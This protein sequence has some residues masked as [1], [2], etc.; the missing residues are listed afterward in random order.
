M[1]VPSQ[2]VDWFKISK[3]SVDALREDSAALRAENIALRT[4]LQTTKANFSW[5]TLRVNAL[6]MERA[7]LLEKVTGVKVAV[8]EIAR[9]LPI[10]QLVN[11]LS[12]EDMGDDMAKKLGLPVYSS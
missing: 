3:E 8:P 2:V 1:W 5:L 6:E 7:V 10:D 12:F 11:Q 9:P 4:E